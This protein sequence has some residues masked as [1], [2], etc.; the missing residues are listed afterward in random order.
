MRSNALEISCES[1][2]LAGSLHFP[3]EG[4]IVGRW[5]WEFCYWELM[6]SVTRTFRALGGKKY[7]CTSS[8]NETKA[9][10]SGRWPLGGSLPSE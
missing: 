8:S 3:V 10:R 1:S 5:S 4:G 2:H 6:L 7:A 9:S